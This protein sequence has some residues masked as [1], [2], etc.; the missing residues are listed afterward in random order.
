MEA[1]FA[2]LAANVE[3]TR[4]LLFAAIP[5]IPPTA[6]CRCQERRPLGE[7]AGDRLRRR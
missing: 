2:M 4:Q 6:T 3:R 7:A 5:A 1:V